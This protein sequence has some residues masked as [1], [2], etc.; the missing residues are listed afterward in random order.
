[1][2]EGITIQHVAV[3]CSDHQ[4]ADKFFTVILGI[5]KVKSTILSEELSTAI[6]KINKNVHFD[7]YENGKTRFEVFINTARRE[8]TYAHI[9]IEV[10]NKGDFI[11]RCKQQ[12]LDPFFVEK[13][14]KQLLFV[15]DFS[16]NL[17][18]VK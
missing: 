13:D 2:A 16:G 17:Y 15:R 9:C 1:M 11:A 12:G 7:F 8:S 4:S 6:F 10:D 14:G 5:P 3:E 18:E